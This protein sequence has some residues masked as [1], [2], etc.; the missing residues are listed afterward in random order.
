MDKNYP[1]SIYL[2]DVDDQYS[3]PSKPM[4]RLSRSGN[5]LFLSI[6]TI[7][8][9]NKTETFTKTAEVAVTGSAFYKAFAAF[10]DWKDVM[11]AKAS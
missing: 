5:I 3:P 10:C 7:Q 6:G 8:E 1:D 2:M 11:H 4:L 9:D